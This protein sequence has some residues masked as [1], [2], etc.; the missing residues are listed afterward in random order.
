MARAQRGHRTRAHVGQAGGIDE[1]DPDLDDLVAGQSAGHRAVA[2]GQRL[3]NIALKMTRGGVV[4]GLVT[5]ATEIECEGADDSSAR[6]QA[7]SSDDEG[8]HASTHTRRAVARRAQ[9]E[10]TNRRLPG[11]NRDR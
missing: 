7:A 1:R 8:D 4:T 2:E 11:G 3:T 6:A 9:D 5:D 10:P